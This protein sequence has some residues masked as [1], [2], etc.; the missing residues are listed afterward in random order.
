MRCTRDITGLNRL[1]SNRVYSRR[2]NDHYYNYGPLPKKTEESED[3]KIRKDINTTIIEMIKE[4]KN[5]IQIELHLKNLYPNY[6]EYIL[7]MISHQFSKMNASK[8]AN[9]KDDKT[10]EG[11]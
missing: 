6:S 5:D 10:G 8:A 3:T 9:S 4:G 7:K 1:T 2:P 11:R